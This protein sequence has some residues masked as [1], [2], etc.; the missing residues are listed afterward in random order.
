M[1]QKSA[2]VAPEVMVISVAGSYVA[3][4]WAA[5]FPAMASLS[6][7]TPCMGAYWLLPCFMCA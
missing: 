4:Y 6:A 7:R 3:P 2:S 5:I 1:A